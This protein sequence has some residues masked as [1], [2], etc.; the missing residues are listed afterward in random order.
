MNIRKI[1]HIGIA[2]R[3]IEKS[4]ALFTA[5]LGNAPYKKE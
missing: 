1:E 5:L 2:V 4:N 3:D